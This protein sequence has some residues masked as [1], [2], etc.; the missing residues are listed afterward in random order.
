MR[1]S[2]AALCFAFSALA[3]GGAL[4]LHAQT[5]L[6][7]GST[8]IYGGGDASSRAW[9]AP[10]VG[11]ILV[12]RW[13]YDD[14]DGTVGIL[15]S[16]GAMPTKGHPFFEA[17]G[18]NGRAC[19]TCH[20]PA[21]GMSLSLASVRERWDETRGE[22]PLFAAVDGAN[23]PDQPRE[24][25]S[26]HSLLLERGLVRIALPWPPKDSYGSTVKPDF[27][28]EV[29][30]DPT[31]CNRSTRYG[32]GSA[33]P[34]VSVYRRPRQTANLRYAMTGSAPHSRSGSR[35]TTWP[36]RRCSRKPRR[37]PGRWCSCGR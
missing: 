13:S 20:Q 11:E 37:C 9:W 27:K 34:A 25:K 28:L 8:S 5:R 12:A 6:A 31:G 23:C 29:V 17:I 35:K 22:D 19:V 16:A 10:G 26:S 30:R 1:R 14:P 15:N 18:S 4:L 24:Q 7:Y 36:E 32:L 33:Q 2:T 21:D 3:A